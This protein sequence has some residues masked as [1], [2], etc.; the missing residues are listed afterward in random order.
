M[1]YTAKPLLERRDLSDD[2][3]R[4]CEDQCR[5]KSMKQVIC[6]MIAER[7]KFPEMV[8]KSQG[9]PGQRLPQIYRERAERPL[10]QIHVE[11][12]DM[13]IIQD[14]DMIIH[15]RETAE[16]PADIEQK[17]NNSGNKCQPGDRVQKHIVIML[18]I[19]QCLSL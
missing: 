19:W 11:I 13:N 9:Y 16:K 14:I 7:I 5:V 15:W 3:V 17:S 18:F 2:G 1:P 12:P 8:V 6:Q 4:N 10:E